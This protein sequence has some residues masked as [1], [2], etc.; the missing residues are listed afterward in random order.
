VEK[1]LNGRI[2]FL[3]VEVKC[4]SQASKVSVI[5]MCFRVINFTS[6]SMNFL[7][8]FVLSRQCDILDCPDSVI[9][10]SFQKTIIS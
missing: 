9:F 5:H 8:D 7:L 10:F 6:V 1:A 3:R 2:V 4:L